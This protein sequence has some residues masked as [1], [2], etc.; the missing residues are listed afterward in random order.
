MILKCAQ[1][2]LPEKQVY[3]QK[4][5]PKSIREISNYIPKF[6]LII[7]LATLFNSLYGQVRIKEKVEIVPKVPN[8][9]ETYSTSEM[10]TI[11]AIVEW[12]TTGETK[13]W[14]RAKM[15]LINGCNADQIESEY[16][17]DGYIEL[18]LSTDLAA[19]FDINV[20]TESNN[21]PIDNSWFAS[22]FAYNLKI[23]ADGILVEET[24]NNT[25]VSPWRANISLRFG[26]YA[27]NNYSDA[28]CYDEEVPF[29]ID[30]IECEP[31]LWTS[32]SSN[33]NVSIIEGAEYTSFYSYYTDEAL[34]DNLS[35]TTDIH[36]NYNTAWGE[37]HLNYDEEYSESSEPKEVILEAEVDGLYARDTIIIFPTSNNFAVNAEIQDYI[38][39][40]IRW[41]KLTIDAWLESSGYCEG[42]VEPPENTTFSAE[43]IQGS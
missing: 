28:L 7:I 17:Y 9:M 30:D 43:I 6:I 21:Y 22:G 16:A 40:I 2:I 38:Q 15:R 5:K 20:Y 3:L 35:F 29:Y 10:H 8:K 39:S 24:S 32:L 12:D 34:G 33:V 31:A 42:I 14:L 23:Y 1:S 41:E 19:R 11:K 27:A 36:G 4:P 37:V 18:K 26:S 13:H 25:S